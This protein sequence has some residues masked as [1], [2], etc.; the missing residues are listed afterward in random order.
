MQTFHLVALYAFGIWI[1]YLTFET[2]VRCVLAC[3]EALATAL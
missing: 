2:P 1:A 3:F